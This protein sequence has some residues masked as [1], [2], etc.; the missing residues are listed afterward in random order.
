MH[1]K[2]DNIKIEYGLNKQYEALYWL[3]LTWHKV[4]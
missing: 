4:Q 2:D 1:M 3:K